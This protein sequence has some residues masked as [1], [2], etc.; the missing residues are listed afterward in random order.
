MKDIF[1]CMCLSFWG[2]IFFYSCT[3]GK[4]TKYL[5]CPGNKKPRSFLKNE[6]LSPT[7][8]T[9]L[10]TNTLAD[11]LN[12]VLSSLTCMIPTGVEPVLP[13]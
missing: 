11:Y 10:N 6:A 12:N 3:E 5:S 1:P 4:S 13:A 7:D 8:H 2:L 9:P